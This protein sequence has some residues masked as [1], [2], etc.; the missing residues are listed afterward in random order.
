[1]FQVFAKVLSLQA[2]KLQC[3][4]CSVQ[5]VQSPEARDGQI[6]LVHHHL[7]EQPPHG[8]HEHDDE[9]EGGP[10]DCDDDLDEIDNSDT[11]FGGNH[12]MPL[13]WGEF[14]V[15]QLIADNAGGYAETP[16]THESI[17]NKLLLLNIDC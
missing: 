5:R 10:D 14:A 7:R 12:Y 11:D 3:S 4:R 2:V 13:N 9:E 16:T 17:K 6:T 15:S 1:M 8:Q